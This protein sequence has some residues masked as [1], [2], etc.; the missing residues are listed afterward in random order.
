MKS[1][2][3]RCARAPDTIMS[4]PTAAGTGVS[5]FA[6]YVRTFNCKVPVDAISF[7]YDCSQGQIRPLDPKFVQLKKA[8]MALNPPLAPVR[9][10]LCWQSDA[11]GKAF[12]CLGGQ[13]C[14][15]VLKAIKAEKEAE[16]LHVPDWAQVVYATVLHPD[17]T[18]DIRRQIAGDHQ[19]RQ[20]AVPT[21]LSRWVWALLQTPSSSKLVD[22][23]KA[24]TAVS[25]WKRYTHDADY[26]KEYCALGK[27]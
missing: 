9:E 8:D 27:W 6:K 15:A 1:N 2:L 23:L 12:V 17:T 3:F 16:G 13:H 21:R 7:D 18:I 14:V 4:Q 24:A 26:V 25:G 20:K 11:T 5:A 19:H 22:R 10:L